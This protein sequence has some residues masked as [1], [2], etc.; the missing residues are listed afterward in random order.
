MVRLLSH[1]QVI[2]PPGAND[3]DNEDS[4]EDILASAPGL[5]FTDNLPNQHG[6]PRSVIVYK[7]PRFGDVR[8]RATDVETGRDG[9]LFSHFLWNAGVLMAVLVE[10]VD[11]ERWGVGGQSVLELGAGALPS[12]GNSREWM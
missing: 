8:L 6:D 1:I 4:P 10:S 11:D 3:E 7:S 5:I 9:N 2:S 12:M